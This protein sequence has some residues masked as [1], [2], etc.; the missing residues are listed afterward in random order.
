[1]HQPNPPPSSRYSMC[2]SEQRETERERSYC[3]NLIIPR[4]NNAS[5]TVFQKHWT[6]QSIIKLAPDRIQDQSSKSRWVALGGHKDLEMTA[7]RQSW[8]PSCRQVDPLRHYCRSGIITN[9]AVKWRSIIIEPLGAGGRRHVTRTE[10]TP[11]PLSA[12]YRDLGFSDFFCAVADA[13]RNTLLPDTCWM[14]RRLETFPSGLPPPLCLQ[15]SF[16]KTILFILIG[17]NVKTRLI[18]PPTINKVA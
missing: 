17:S 16:R 11:G 14:V 13:D 6:E 8:L 7:T 1:M 15:T 10:G 9:A 12:P 3:M 5:R 18:N 4:V 2:N